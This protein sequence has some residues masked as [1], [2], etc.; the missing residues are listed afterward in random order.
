M[1]T[2]TDRVR[3]R[4]V[5]IA[6]IVFSLFAA[7]VVRL[8]SLQVLDGKEYV[9]RAQ[10]NAVRIIVDEAPRGR[11]F[12]RNG[13][14]IVRNRTS[15]AVG[16]RR[17][18]LPAG[19][20]G[21]LVKQRL[22]ELLGIDRTELEDRLADLRVAPFDPVVV[23]RDVPP[24]II[25]AISE[26]RELYPGVEALTLAARDYP[27]GSIA[28]HVIGYLTEI[29][30]DELEAMS[31]YRPGDRIGRTGIERELESELRGRPG[32]RKLEVDA[33]GNVLSTINALAPIPGNDVKL[34]L[35]SRL[36][37]IAE[38]ALAN[39]L[40]LAR[41]SVF[42]EDGTSFKA[43]AGAVVVMDPRTGA[44]RAMASAPDFDL[45][46]FVGGIGVDDYKRLTRPD[47]HQPLLNRAT[48]AAYPPGSTFKPVMVSAAL[49]EGRATEHTRFP[50]QTEFEFG[51][52]TFRNWRPRNAHLTLREAL[53]ESCDTPFY[54]LARDWWINEL[55]SEDA[56]RPPREIIQEYARRFGLD[57]ETG[58]ELPGYEAD[59]RIP[60]RRWRLEYWE[61]NKDA[62][63]RTARR[64]DDPLFTDLCERGFVWRGGD[65][66]NLS[67]GQ[68]DILVS[69]IQL[70]TMYGAIANGGR[71]V[72]PYL[73]DRI[74]RRDGTSLELQ[75][76]ADRGRVGVSRR[77]LGYIRSALEAVATVGTAAYP[78]R[79]WPHDRIRVAAK[80][81]SAE[82][83]GKQ[84]FSWFAAFAPAN[85]PRYVVVSVV[86]EAGSG[87]GTSG[88]IVRR[89]L[90]GAFHLPP[91]PFGF[92]GVSD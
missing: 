78:F 52:R 6:V 59:G 3:A 43:P 70:A 14:V 64:T 11:I 90:D 10:R 39:G 41:N 82:I 8:Y 68:G 7:I 23:A 27:K 88:P 86:E 5:V 65:S 92:G 54:V 42:K 25:F 35:D 87:S 1:T 57:A 61:A 71:V 13:R 77:V 34:T 46:D 33:S 55:R 67:I 84:P 21:E 22:I 9:F 19:D 28:P 73:V 60:D 80:T 50:C 81:G 83:A 24:R 40:R 37:R 79:G 32:R 89:I 74:D 53:I 72:T 31:G 91:L 38:D 47:A 45:E 12:D 16:V 49:S 69:P 18:D 85:N 26:H 76:A 4:V 63:C 15:L 30:A 17:P 75:P 20:E 44:I 62:Y 56:G 66:V 51:D 58:I 2:V 48:Q 29:D 36:Q